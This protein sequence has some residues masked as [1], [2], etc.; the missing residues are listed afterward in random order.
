M[1]ISTRTEQMIRKSEMGIL[2]Y[3]G[4][5]RIDLEVMPNVSSRAQNAKQRGVTAV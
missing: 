1:L 2:R 3:W 5:R 4:E